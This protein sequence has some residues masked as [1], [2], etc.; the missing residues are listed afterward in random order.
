MT[1]VPRSTAQAYSVGLLNSLTG[2]MSDSERLVIEATRLAINE[3]NASGG[4]LGHEIVPVIRDGASRAEDFAEQATRLFVEDNIRVIFGCWTSASRKALLPVLQRHD[5]MLFYPLQYEGLEESPNV[6]YTGSTLNQQIEP[7]VDWAMDQGWRTA[8]FVGS[9]YVYPRTANTLMHGILEKRGGVVVDES[10]LPLEGYD[11]RPVVEQIVAAKPDVIFSTINGAANID[12]FR[13][14]AKVGAS[15]EHLPVVSFSFSETELALVP[16]ATGHYACWD[17][18]STCRSEVNRHFLPRIREFVGS[19]CPVSSPMANAYTQVF[20]WKAI[21]E[22]VGSFDVSAL[23]NFSFIMV[24]G[25]CGMMELKQNHHVRKRAIIGQAREDGEFEIIWQYPEMIDPEPWFGVQSLLHGRIIHQA[26][27]AFPTVVDLHATLRREKEIQEEL[28]RELNQKQVELERARDAA[29]AANE[30]KSDFLAAMSHEIRTPMNGIL[31]MAQLLG[32][33]ELSNTQSEQLGVILSSAESLLTIINDILDFSKIKA[34]RIDLESVGFSLHDLLSESLQLLSPKAHSRGMEIELDID[35]DMPD[36]RSGDPTRIRQVLMNLVSNA[37]KFTENGRIVVRVGPVSK[38]DIPPNSQRQVAGHRHSA[39]APLICLQVQDTGIGISQEAQARVFQPFV[40][41]DSGTTR[42]YGG[43]GLG[44]VI[45][46]R[47][48]EI[49]GGDLSLES[50]LGE[51]ATF[52]ATFPLPIAEKLEVGQT[53]PQ[54]TPPADLLHGRRVLLVDDNEVNLRVARGMLHGMGITVD[55]AANAERAKQLVDA[56]IADENPCYDGMIFDAMM[57]VT[58]GWALARWIR[59]QPGCRDIPLILASSSIG[60]GKNTSSNDA[61]LFAAVLAKPL[62]RSAL[63]RTLASIMTDWRPEKL[64][65]PPTQVEQRR[66]L[67]VEDSLVNQK[68]AEGFLTK[69]GH[70]VTIA[71]NGQDALELLTS[72]NAFDLI[73]MDIQMPVLDGLETTR[74]LRQREQERGWP[75]W[76]V[77]ALTGNAMAEEKVECLAAGMD[78]CLTKPM[79]LKEVQVLVSETPRRM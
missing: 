56:Q 1:I 6:I 63:L 27:E 7:A 50:V 47:L 68:I 19:N 23:R 5:G 34:G 41:A 35:L 53:C 73:L 71:E 69:G 64:A 8:A 36:I 51:G 40:Q 30:A 62:R 12:F 49:M 26:L 79:N 60:S 52:T 11:V 32:D 77:I 25:P 58:D 14:L 18:F 31:G 55:E 16:E 57:P 46:K 22:S 70:S 48:V 61:D 9:D 65:T 2:V 38:F 13:H 74:R 39:E 28:I 17:Y 29:E 33:G 4:V 75:R 15:V 3:I 10:Y 42:K 44:L 45:S 43:T 20:L 21:V 72:P 37:I 78:G 24:D 66:V 67:V 54:A 59:K 76:P